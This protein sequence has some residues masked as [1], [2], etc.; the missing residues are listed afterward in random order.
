MSSILLTNYYSETTLQVI[1]EMLPLGFELLSLDKPGKEDILKKAPYADYFLVGGRTLIDREI[2]NAS[3]KLRMIQ[4]SGVGLDSLDLKALQ[5]RAI[6]IYV[7]VGVNS[8]SVA[9]HTILLILSVLRNLPKVHSSVKSGEWKKHEFGLQNND[10]FGK[11]VGLIGMGAIGTIVAEMLRPFGVKI[12][13]TKPVKF[14][15]EEETRL[16][17][18]YCDFQQLI[19]SSDIISLHCPYSPETHC[20]IGAKEI[21]SMK[22]GA[23]IINTGRGRLIDQAALAGALK[24]GHIKGAGLDVF[25]QE[26]IPANNSL[27]DLDNMVLTPHLSGITTE[28]FRRMIR[29]AFENISSFDEG[30]LSIIESKRLTTNAV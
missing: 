24:T 26:P 13:Y 30:N 5:E 15:N 16:Q 23:I 6:P 10:L 11:T 28:T 29:S 2:L 17:V 21:Q 8:R 20:L 1:K 25:E 19:K 9:E 7:N 22:S 14:A 4:R 18:Q 3:P 12:L 27:F